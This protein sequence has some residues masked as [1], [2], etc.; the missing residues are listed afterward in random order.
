MIIAYHEPGVEK[1]KI[2][3]KV[4]LL[5]ALAGFHRLKDFPEDLECA[6]FSRLVDDLSPVDSGVCEYCSNVID[7]FLTPLSRDGRFDHSELGENQRLGSLEVRIDSLY[8]PLPSLR[9]AL[10]Q[11]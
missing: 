11:D 5:T 8:Y 7:V 6:I 1:R 3:K 4:I 2:A 10:D 9:R